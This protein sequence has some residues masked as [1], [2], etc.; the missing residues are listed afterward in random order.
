MMLSR[1]PVSN[2]GKC[3]A[4]GPTLGQAP[5]PTPTAVQLVFDRGKS[6]LAEHEMFWACGVGCEWTVAVVRTLAVGDRNW[7]QGSFRRTRI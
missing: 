1:R 2:P 3:E 7:V 4:L 5:L 6:L